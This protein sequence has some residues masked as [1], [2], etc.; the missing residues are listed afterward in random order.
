ML[1]FGFTEWKAVS[2]SPNVAIENGCPAEYDVRIFDGSENMSFSKKL[3][4]VEVNI[5]DGKVRVVQAGLAPE[6]DQVI[7]LY[8]EQ[9]DLMIQWLREAKEHIYEE[10][11]RNQ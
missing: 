2:K 9:V 1:F 5:Q 10:L 3:E 4:A 11:K 7:S 6:E 8:P